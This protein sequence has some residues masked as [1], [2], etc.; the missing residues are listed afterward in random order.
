MHAYTHTRACTQAVGHR[1]LSC[2]DTPW[3]L[4]HTSLQ[5][6]CV[7][8][9]LH[10][11]LCLSHLH[12]FL[13]HVRLQA[14]PCGKLIFGVHA[15]VCKQPFVSDALLLL[16]KPTAEPCNYSQTPASAAEDCRRPR[17]W[18]LRLKST[19]TV[20]VIPRSVKLYPDVLCCFSALVSPTQERKLNSWHP[21][22]GREDGMSSSA[23]CS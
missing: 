6:V 14:G 10:R 11:Q 22:A 20:S 15:R 17:S 16:H 12:Q 4:L 3:I 5:R 23:V 19:T 9:C 18:Q 8:K 7:F 1:S 21:S 13:L 2:C